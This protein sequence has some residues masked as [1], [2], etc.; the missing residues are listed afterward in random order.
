MATMGNSIKK[1]AFDNAPVSVGAELVEGQKRR[2]QQRKRFRRIFGNVESV[3]ATD[4]IRAVEAE[5]KTSKRHLL[6]KRL[7]ED[8]LAELIRVQ[9]PQMQQGAEG[10]RIETRIHLDDLVNLLLRPDL[11]E[12]VSPDLWDAA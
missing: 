8:L 9:G 5:K 3:S 10:A 11:A 7:M 4:I 6:D 1:T 2:H 12:Q